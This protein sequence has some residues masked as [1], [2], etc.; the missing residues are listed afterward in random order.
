MNEEQERI[1]SERLRKIQTICSRVANFESF[2]KSLLWG[3][4]KVTTP[5]ASVM[6][7][8][9]TFNSFC[10]RNLTSSF[11]ENKKFFASFIHPLLEVIGRVSKCGF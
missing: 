11:Q 3:I 5:S 4:L 7:S 6:S 2:S 9:T 8:W 10:T 1:D